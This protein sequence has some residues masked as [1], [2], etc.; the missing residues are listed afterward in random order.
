LIVA[1]EYSIKVAIDDDNGVL[2]IVAMDDTMVAIV[3]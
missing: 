3:S 2:L 1:Q